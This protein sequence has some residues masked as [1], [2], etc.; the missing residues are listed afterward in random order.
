V[1]HDTF[2]AE[3]GDDAT[4]G[5]LAFVEA[6]LAARPARILDVGCGLG[7]HGRA[8]ALAGHRVTAVERDG[9]IADRLRRLPG[10]DRLD[11]RVMDCRALPRL[12]A[13][14]YDAVLSFWASSAARTRSTS[15]CSSPTRCAAW[16]PATAWS[17]S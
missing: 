5:E 4:R 2:A 13:G 1:R 3:G 11:V 14:A 6:L 10:G 16:R 12:L 7:R 15:S 17:G 8:L 9:V